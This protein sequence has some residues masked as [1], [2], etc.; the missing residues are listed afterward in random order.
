MDFKDSVS[1]Q[2]LILLLDAKCVLMR[3]NSRFV[4]IG[5]AFRVEGES[6]EA[7]IAQAWHRRTG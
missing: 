2:R 5:P 7:T 6:I 4:I 3:E 1:W